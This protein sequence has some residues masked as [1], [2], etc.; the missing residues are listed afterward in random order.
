MELNSLYEYLYDFGTMLKSDTCLSI[1][2]DGFRPWSHVYKD[3]GRSRK[4]YGKVDRNLT[5]DLLRLRLDDTREDA[6]KYAVILRAVLGC[7]GTGIIESLEFTLKDYLR[8][9]NGPLRN[10]RAGIVGNKSCC[11][12]GLS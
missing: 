8:Q 4:F 3:K 12:N 9:T 1:F 2:D 10:D 5:S 6:D 7:F 11:K